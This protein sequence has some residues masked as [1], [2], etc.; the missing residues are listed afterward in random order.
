VGR[1]IDVEQLVDASGVASM[2]GLKH[3]NTVANYQRRYSDFPPPV[4][5]ASHGRCKL[6][7]RSDVERWAERRAKAGRVRR[8]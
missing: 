1:R 5:V 3:R 8:R 2:L 7:S 4:F 6:W